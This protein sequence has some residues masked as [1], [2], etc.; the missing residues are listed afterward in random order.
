MCEPLCRGLIRPAQQLGH[1]M[2]A[3]VEEH[4]DTGYV[5]RGR[6]PE[7]RRRHRV[8]ITE[9]GREAP[10]RAREGMDAIENE[11]PQALDAER[12]AT[13]LSLLARALQGAPSGYIRASSAGPPYCRYQERAPPPGVATARRNES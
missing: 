8:Q 12:R 11:V 1:V 10:A 7:D 4:E 3:H 5:V 2:G 6:D 13:L 9:A